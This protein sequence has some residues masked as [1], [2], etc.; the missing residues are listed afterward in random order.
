MSARQEAIGKEEL[1]G[2]AS[3][4]RLGSDV[5]HVLSK[6]FKITALGGLMTMEKGA[7][8]SAGEAE[9]K[10]LDKI[11][12]RCKS[13]GSDELKDLSDDERY[14][15]LL[16]MVEGSRARWPECQKRQQQAAGLK[17]GGKGA[18]LAVDEEQ[19]WRVVAKQRGG[20]ALPEEERANSKTIRFLA[21]GLSDADGRR[22][23]IL[24]LK[25]V[26]AV[27]GRVGH[28]DPPE[29]KEEEKGTPKKGLKGPLLGWSQ[30]QRRTRLAFH[31]LAAV[32]GLQLTNDRHHPPC[33][34]KGDG[35]FMSEGQPTITLDA[36]YA[37]VMDAYFFLSDR[38][39]RESDPRAAEACFDRF[40]AH[41]S[42]RVADAGLHRN[43][44]AAALREARE[45]Y[46]TTDQVA[47]LVTQE[48]RSGGSTPSTGGAQRETA[49]KRGL[50][51]TEER[52]SKK[53]KKG[54]TGKNGKNGKT[55]EEERPPKKGKTGAAP[56][57]GGV[58][59]GKRYGPGTAPGVCRNYRALGKCAFGD[60]CVWK[61]TRDEDSDADDDREL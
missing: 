41:L 50:F 11:A 27:Q 26:G 25:D 31:G 47:E 36:T 19:L 9:A 33:R 2:V 55:E 35:D 5:I 61:H 24:A 43:S 46:A 6:H 13:D 49:A 21:E 14:G 56:K 45:A 3:T 57:G 20:R 48:S 1:D 58:V 34:S 54:K 17:I 39:G 38:Q 52:A 60:N 37:E 10:C 23:P 18:V 32:G 12:A 8:R 51:Q 28:D 7:L 15:R 22:L 44:L 30:V 42:G 40:W 16:E 29:K 4:V 53:G 59:G